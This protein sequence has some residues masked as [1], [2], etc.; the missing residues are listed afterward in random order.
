MAF[1]R[2]AVH[3]KYLAERDRRLVPRRGELRDLS[4]DRVAAQYR[5]DPFTPYLE[6]DAVNDDPDVVVLGGGIAGLLAAVQLRK[7]GIQRIRIIDHA[8]GIGGTW[9]WNRYPGIA[10]DVESYVYMPLLEELGYIPTEKYAKGAEIFAH[11]RRIAERY[12]I[13]QPR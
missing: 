13:A 10:C 5:T 7:N 4:N 6:R 8:G 12:D 3:S 1:D 9:Y 2:D 11:C